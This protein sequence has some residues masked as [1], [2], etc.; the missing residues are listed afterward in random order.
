MIVN[1]F[2]LLIL[3]MFWAF[4][5]GTET[6]FISVNRFK[7][8][9]LKKKGKKN[10]IVA[11]Y[12]LEKPDRLLT[13]TLVGTNF[14][15][16]MAANITAVLFYNILEKSEPVISIVVL[17]VISLILCEIIPKNLALKNSLKITLLF[18]YPLYVFYFIFYPI[19][20]IFSF[21]SKIFIRL[22]GASH[23]SSI[24][25]MFSKKDDVKI[26]LTAQLIKS[27]TKEERRYFV[28]S[29]DFGD[30]ELS[31]IMIPLVEIRALSINEKIELCYQFVR[32]YHKCYIPVYEERIDNIVGV[33]YVNDL[34]KV[35]KNLRLSA[36]MR[37]PLFVPEN[38][39]INELYR[40]LYV[41]DIPVV[42]AVDEY[43]GVTGIGTIYDIGEE[44]IG[45][46]S[47]F[48]EKENI[49][50][51]IKDNEYLCTGDVEIDE[52]NHR[53]SIDIFVEDFTTINGLVLK[54]LG[55]IPKKGDYIEANGYRF[56]VEKGGEKKV[57]LIRIMA[58]KRD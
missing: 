32:E 16:V 51:K 10:A 5:A 25:N 28:D 43:G 47:V 54:K 39:N 21:I 45:E 22:I 27:I 44:I 1:V 34:F 35:D 23:S 9:N 38:K 2:L 11:Y 55:K 12:L 56:I 33:I 13:T 40:E 58:Q 19:C 49:F 50:V 29:L 31:D 41:K 42:F 48:D 36:V 24:L 14:S 6:A 18:S 15:L 57:E 37:E 4:F 52:V 30:K 17:T 53:L 20:K 7:L 3:F 26:F 8:N 46:I